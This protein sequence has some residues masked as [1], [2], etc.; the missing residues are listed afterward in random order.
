MKIALVIATHRRPDVLQPVL[1]NLLSCQRIPDHII[2][3]AVD[4]ADIPKIDLEAANV[5]SVFGSAG[6]TRQRNRG[7]S[8]VIDTAD[9][10]AF[11][12]DDF[13]VGDDYFLNM[14]SIFAR[15]VSIVGVT[16]EVIADGATSL[17]LTSRRDSN[18]LSNTASEKNP[19][20]SCAKLEARMAATWR[21]GPPV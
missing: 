1:T 11:I 4:P 19:R 3:S 18:W 8:C 14:E 20:P 5:R 13:I 9:F 6:L 7:M 21:F 16:G 2:I 17:G 15:D 12:D 10:I